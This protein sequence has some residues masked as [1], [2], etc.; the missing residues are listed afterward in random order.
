LIALLRRGPNRNGKAAKA[1][2][3]SKEEGG[4]GKQGSIYDSTLSP[5]IGGDFGLYCELVQGGRLYEYML[6]QMGREVSKEA[7]DW[8]KKRFL[9]DVIA[10]KKANKAGDEYPSEVE[11]AFQELFPSVWSYMGWK[12]KDTRTRAGVC[13]G[14]RWRVPPDQIRP[15]IPGRS[16]DWR[17][18]DS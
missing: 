1:G 9:T 17:S 7:R 2:R 18:G 8:L 11:D 13:V 16:G 4:Q 3:G 15:P 14:T 10:K 5:P 12:G 6:R